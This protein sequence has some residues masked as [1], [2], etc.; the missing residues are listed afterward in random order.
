MNWIGLLVIVCIFVLI[1]WL[2]SLL[3]NAMKAGRSGM[4]WVL[5]ALLVSG[6][7]SG[8]VLEYFELTDQK[9]LA[10]GIAVFISVVI[11][12]VVLDAGIVGGFVI[13]LGYNVIVGVVVAAALFLGLGA[14]SM[15]ALTGILKMDGVNME[16]GMETSMVPADSGDAGQQATDAMPA[17]TVADDDPDRIIGYK[18]D[19][20][21]KEYS[22]DTVTSEDTSSAMPAEPAKPDYHETLFADAKEYIGYKARITRRDGVKVIGVLDAASDNALDVKRR[23]SGG[24][25]ILPVR[26]GDISLLEIYY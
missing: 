13:S 26:E 11:F 12:A 17:E 5:L 2:T 10:L 4:G 9:L 19:G 22:F 18:V 25:A 20:P 6:V 1:I 14:S 7:I 23:S 3:A 16:Y 21:L 24:Y 8:V 15:G